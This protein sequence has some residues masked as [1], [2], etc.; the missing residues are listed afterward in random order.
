M[1]GGSWAGYGWRCL[2]VRRLPMKLPGAALAP[3]HGWPSRCL[4]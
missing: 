4:A 1:A 3:I 2:P